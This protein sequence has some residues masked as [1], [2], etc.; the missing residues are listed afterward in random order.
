MGRVVSNT[1]SQLATT[2][3][4]L[5]STFSRSS[6]AWLGATDCVCS[7]NSPHYEAVNGSGRLAIFGGSSTVCTFC[8]IRC[9]FVYMVAVSISKSSR[10]FL[11]CERNQQKHGN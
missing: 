5:V 3:K 8:T 9:N 7:L 11:Y 1:L 2:N 6:S 4:L 10:F